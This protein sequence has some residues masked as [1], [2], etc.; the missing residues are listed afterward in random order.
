MADVKQEKLETDELKNSAGGLSSG[1]YYWID[2]N[3]CIGCGY[4]CNVCPTYAIRDDGYGYT[5]ITSSC[6]CC[7]HCIGSCPF[8]AIHV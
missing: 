6:V 1:S 3:S 4:C 5:I 7:G 2:Q 8:G